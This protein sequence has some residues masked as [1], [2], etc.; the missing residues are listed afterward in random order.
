MIQALFYYPIL[1]ARTGAPIVHF[2]DPELLPGALILRLLGRKVIY[3]VHEDVPAD[4]HDKEW[5]SPLLR[6]PVAVMADY[7]ERACAHCMTRVVA[8][9]PNIAKRFRSEKVTLVQNFP[10]LSEM[11]DSSESDVAY[12][13]RRKRFVYIGSITE[14]RGARSMV[15]AL[16]ILSA[17]SEARLA[18]GGEI[19]PE[20]LD[21]ELRSMVPWERV[22]WLGWCDRRK[23]MEELGKARAGLVLFQPARNHVESQPNKLFEYMSAG[24]PVIAS[25]FPLWRGIIDAAKCG[26][27]VDPSVPADIAAAMKWILDNPEEA[28]EMGRRGRDAVRNKYNWEK[29]AEALIAMYAA[30]TDEPGGR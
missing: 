6:K 27:L 26:V 28:A 13:Q 15:N 17:S 20:S 4:V 7:I 25:D 21:R 30:L 29:E 16:E 19:W 14:I 8:A 22:D 11:G 2:H 12:N 18:L 10:L 9:T 3:D 1:A 23:M 5:I 24:I